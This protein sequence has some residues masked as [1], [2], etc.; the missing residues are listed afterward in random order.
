MTA[1]IIIA[2][3]VNTALE[4]GLHH[5]ALS[6]A[7][8]A[9]R[10]GPVLVA[11]G[12]VLTQYL[13]PGER[14]LFSPLR[15]AN[16]FFHLYESIWMLAG[17]NDVASVARYAK[18]MDSFA[19]ADGKLHGAYGYRWRNFFGFDQLTEIVQQLR[20]DPKTRRAVLTMW[21]PHGDLVPLPGDPEVSKD[22]PCNTQVY[23]DGT[24]GRLNMTVCNR[25]ND[26]VWGAYGAN[27]VHMSFLQE[28]VAVAVGL[29]LGTYYQFSNNY[30]TYVDR[31]D[32][33]RLIQKRADLECYNVMYRAE[34]RYAEGYAAPTPLSSG[35]TSYFQFMEDCVS[36]AQ[37]PTGNALYASNFLTYAVRPLMRAHALYKQGDFGDAIAN[38]RNCVAADWRAAAVEWLERRRRA[39]QSAKAG[40]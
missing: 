31:P 37:D 10:N 18:T 16:P 7:V 14:V 30:H 28:I 38:A 26:I 25:S 23:F 11:P 24:T 6:G 2:R 12:P 5:L 35:W 22:V 33:A 29:P 15:D 34:D 36:I 39:A 20:K 17:C 3:N 40:T 32:V 13:N 8:N 21:A 27:S 19:G 9:S 1:R 4:D